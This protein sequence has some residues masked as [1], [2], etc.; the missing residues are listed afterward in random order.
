[1]PFEW[2]TD[3]Y[4]SSSFWYFVIPLFGSVVNVCPSQKTTPSWFSVGSEAAQLHGEAAE[5]TGQLGTGSVGYG[6][7]AGWLIKDWWCHRNGPIFREN[8]ENSS[9]NSKFG[10]QAVTDLSTALRIRWEGNI[11]IRHLHIWVVVSKYVWTGK[12]TC[13]RV[14]RMC[15]WWRGH[16]LNELM[17]SFWIAMVDCQKVVY[18]A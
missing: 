12:Q 13:N 3:N 18:P 6:W 7:A 5:V 15:R 14:F 1:M 11:Q 4:P 8:T 2:H 17:C 16:E 9:P 10:F